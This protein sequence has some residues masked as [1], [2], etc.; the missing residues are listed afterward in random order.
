MDFTLV[1]MFRNKVVT[2]SVFPPGEMLRYK[3]LKEAKENPGIVET[4]KEGP[5]RKGLLWDK[6]EVLVVNVHTGFVEKP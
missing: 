4:S 3:L 6:P 1:A 2:T 5:I